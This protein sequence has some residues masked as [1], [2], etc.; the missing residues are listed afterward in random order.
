MPELEMDILKTGFT[1]LRGV[2]SPSE[3]ALF[4]EQALK[5]FSQGGGFPDSTGRAHPDW[6]KTSQLKTMYAIWSS[7]NIPGLI[8]KLIGQKVEF[9]GHSDLHLNRNVG[10]HKDRLN[11]E[12]KKFELNNPWEVCNGETMKIYKAN[13]YLQAH[14][15]N[16]DGLIVREGSHLTETMDDG[17]VSVI[18]PSIGDV[19]VFDQRITHMAQWSGGY[20]RLLICMGYGVNN[21][22]FEQFKKG[23]EFRQAKQ[24]DRA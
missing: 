7:K 13:L 22:F 11:N 23:T 20:D 6:I 5:F 19:V 12:A 18:H 15:D 16:Y 3:I 9:I 24:N 10:W 21:I 17:E 4:R 8:S 14:D 2:F 1:T